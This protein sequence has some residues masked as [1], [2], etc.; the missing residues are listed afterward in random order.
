[1]PALSPPG[2]R[3]L[4]RCRTT[5]VLLLPVGLEFLQHLAGIVRASGHCVGVAKYAS[6]LEL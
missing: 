2:H 3:A 6:I 4:L 5:S 1:M